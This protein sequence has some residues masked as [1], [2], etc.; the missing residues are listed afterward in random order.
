MLGHSFLCAELLSLVDLSR[1]TLYARN[2]TTLINDRKVVAA[3]TEN[4]RQRYGDMVPILQSMIEPDTATRASA[5][6]ACAAFREAMLKV[7]P[8]GERAML[9]QLLT[10]CL[11]NDTSDGWCTS[12]MTLY[13]PLLLFLHQTSLHH[14]RLN[15]CCVYH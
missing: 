3:E 4:L 7:P 1:G 14:A 13:H 5:A 15:R 9:Q 12:S 2:T 10:G 11:Q 6:E 8:Q